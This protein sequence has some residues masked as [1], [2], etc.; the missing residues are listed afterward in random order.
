MNKDDFQ[1]LQAGN[2]PKNTLRSTGWAFSVPVPQPKHE[3]IVEDDFS[4]I[5][6]NEGP[7]QDFPYN[8]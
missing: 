7:A 1:S 8:H 3:E 2:Q 6:I 5:D 4:S